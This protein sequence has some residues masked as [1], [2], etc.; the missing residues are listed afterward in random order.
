MDL[1]ADTQV[2]SGKLTHRIKEDTHKKIS[3]G[4]F[5]KTDFWDKIPYKTAS[6]LF[7]S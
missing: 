1:C 3:N 6:D 2:T 7:N 5:S 4:K